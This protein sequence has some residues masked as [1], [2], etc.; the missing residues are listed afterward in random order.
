[1]NFSTGTGGIDISEIFKMFAGGNDRGIIFDFLK[2]KVLI[3]LEVLQ[4]L[5]ILMKVLGDS[6]SLLPLEEEEVEM[7][8]VKLQDLLLH[9]NSNNFFCEGEKFANLF[10]F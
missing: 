1:M 7:D 4:V 5:V 9:L 2:K 6:L 8:A 3:L 10:V